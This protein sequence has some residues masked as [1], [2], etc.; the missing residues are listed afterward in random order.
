MHIYFS[1]IGGV[2]VGPL[3]EIARDAGHSVAGS[4][5]STSLMTKK[6]ASEGVEFS[7]NQDGSFLREVHDKSPIDWFVYTTALPSNHPE[8]LMAKDLGIKTSK[9]G[10]LLAHIIKEHNKKLIAVSGTHGKTST[11]SMMV[12]VFKQLGIPVSYSIGT[13]LT[14]GPSGHF[15]PESEYFVYECDEFD[16][17]LLE[18][19]PDLSLITSI[20]HDH[21]DTYPTKNDYLQAFQQFGEQSKQIIAWEGN[22]SELFDTHPDAWILND[23]VNVNIPGQHSRRNATLVV[24]A[25]EKLGFGEDIIPLIESFPGVDRR[26]EKLADNLYT[27]YGHHP[28]EIAATL[29]MARELSDDIV[30]V[31]QPHQNIRQHEIK[32][33]YINQFENANLI[34][35][36][37]TYLSREDPSLDILKPEDLTTNI[38]NRENIEFAELNDE[39]W[40]KLQSAR[41][42]G[43]LVLGMGAGSIDGWLREKLLLYQP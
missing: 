39:L 27:D 35:W 17:N 3:A 23:T 32:D 33:Q 34:Y 5:M 7:L 30:L 43:K 25:F 12:W 41:S 6:L 40:Q 26:F 22:H 21:T 14:F 18:F 4:D 8:L 13:T 31:Y 19:W 16:K 20:D 1:G 42:S 24:K 29:Q 11:T 38:T 2:G 28:A 37:P 15:D 10:E 9:R 36:V